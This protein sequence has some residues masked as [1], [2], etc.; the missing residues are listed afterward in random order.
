M[1]KL[2]IN[3]YKKSLYSLMEKHVNGNDKTQ[4]QFLL[5]APV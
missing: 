4:V 1:I 2:I 5:K 3:D